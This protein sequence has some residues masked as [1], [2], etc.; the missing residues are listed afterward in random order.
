MSSFLTQGAGALPGLETFGLVALMLVAGLVFL[1]VEL[2]I[3]PGFGIAGVAG[4]L[5][6]IGGAA[7]AWFLLGPMWGGLAALVTVVM[8]IALTVFGFRSKSL[9]RR[10][11]LDTQL[12]KGGGTESQGLQNLIGVTGI[13]KS[14]LRPAGIALVNDRRLDVV[15]EGGFLEQGTQI[16]IVAVDGPRIVVAK[17][18]E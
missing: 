16:K 4:L 6:I 8:A 17:T 14:D 12:A 5:L 13:A 11:V 7:T 3:L 10:L 1:A 9:R 15:S 2:F 18:N